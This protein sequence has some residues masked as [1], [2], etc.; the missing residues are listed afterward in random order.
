MQFPYLKNTLNETLN[1]PSNE[2]EAKIIT[3]DYVNKIG[4]KQ[5]NQQLTK[6]YQGLLVTFTN[7]IDRYPAIIFDGNSIIYGVTD[8]K[9]AFQKYHNWQTQRLNRDGDRHE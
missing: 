6:A 5:F 9:L 7:Q 2:A 1:L 8:L 4:Q 3:L